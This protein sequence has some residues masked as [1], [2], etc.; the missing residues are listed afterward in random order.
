MSDEDRTLNKDITLNATPE[1]V[2]QALTD[3][4]KTKQFLFGC[5]A[6]ST[7]QVGAPLEFQMTMGGE[8]MTIVKGVIEEVEPHAV[9]QHTCFEAR[10]ENDPSQH[11]TAR[12]QLE[13]VP[14]GTRLTIRQGA[15]PTAEQCAQNSASWDM[16]LG[17]LKQIVE[18]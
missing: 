2:W 1:A 12:Y 5:E 4:E 3:P 16:A 15:F 18:E 11:T 7:W 17:G 13:A 14:E 10:H 9:L 8:T 6:I